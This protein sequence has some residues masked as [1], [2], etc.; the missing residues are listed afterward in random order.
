L[1]SPENFLLPEPDGLQTRTSQDYVFYKLNS[2]TFYLKVT[3]TAMRDKWRN[4]YYIDLES[5]PGKN[6]VGSEIILGSPLI[7]LTAEFPATH[8]WLNELDATANTAL[9]QRVSASPLR[10]RVEIFQRDVNEVV[11]SVCSEIN[12]RD[13]I[14]GSLN[15][16]FLDPEGLELQWTTVEQLARITRMDLIINFSTGGLFRSIGKGYEQVV[17]LFFGTPA[18]R[19]IYRPN[20]NPVSKRRALIDFYRQR[21]ESFGYHIDIDPNLGGNDIAVNNSKNAQVYSMIFASK[22]ELGAKFWKAAAK[23]VK[24][25]MLPGFD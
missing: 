2:L 24:P 12:K 15:I 7:A 19:K 22:H 18:W 23:S 25:P 5:G 10:E 3:N 4:R 20:D 1:I 14:S 11:S 17:D 21:L 8:F 13:R 9:E 16:A 6:T